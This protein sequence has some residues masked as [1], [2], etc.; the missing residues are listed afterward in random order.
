[1]SE[2]SN[3]FIPGDPV[4]ALVSRSGERYWLPG[5][6][7]SVGTGGARVDFAS[8]APARVPFSRLRLGEAR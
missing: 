7:R 3:P 2:S 8:A 5:V 6:V 1:M 4:L